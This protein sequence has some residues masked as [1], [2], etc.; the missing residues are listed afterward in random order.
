[1]RTIKHNPAANGE[2]QWRVLSSLGDLIGPDLSLEQIIEAVYHSVNQLMDAYQFS[3]GQFDE[4]AMT[5]TFK[6]VIE[7]GHHLPDLKVDAT[8]PDRLAPWCV[9]N[10]APIFINDMEIDYQQYVK[11]IP[12]AFIGAR[13]NAALYVPLSYDGKVI[14]LITV[15]TIHKNVYQQHHLFILKTVGDFIVRCIAQ[16]KGLAESKPAPRQKIWKLSAPE[17]LT[18]ASRKLLYQLSE[19]EREVLFFLISGLPNKAI[20]ENLFV[21]AGTI[22]THTL[23][24]YRKM[25]VSNRTAAIIKAV[26]LGWFI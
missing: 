25:E 26:E 15:R 16:E 11:E 21:S 14:G 1:M 8:L 17:K 3:V 4:A 19:R 24:I 6:G 18:P 22:K 10:N 23:N 13:P 5:I 20:A 2:E 12:A 9:L 7:N